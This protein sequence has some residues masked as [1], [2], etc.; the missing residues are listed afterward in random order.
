MDKKRYTILGI[1]AVLTLILSIQLFPFVYT[2]WKL[3]TIPIEEVSEIIYAKYEKDPLSS[4]IV[5]K[6]YCSKADS[7]STVE[8]FVKSFHNGKIKTWQSDKVSSEML[9]L[10]FEDDTVV[11]AY[12]LGDKIGFQYGKYWVDMDDMEGFLLSMK[13]V[14]RIEVKELSN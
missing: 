10:Y 4:E 2:K 5:E 7:E 8:K 12:I 13:P 11:N 1:I 6:K 3:S 9:F 14:E